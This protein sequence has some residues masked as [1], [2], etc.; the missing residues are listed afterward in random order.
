MVLFVAPGPAGTPAFVASR[1]IG[2]A[3]V[4]NR[5]RRRLR[6]AWRSLSIRPREDVQLVFTARPP[7]ASAT[8]QE[9]CDDMAG[10]LEAAG[11]RPR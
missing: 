7:I 11:V 2:G 4:R 3:V 6:E 10:V 9:V 5:V 8:F 1:R